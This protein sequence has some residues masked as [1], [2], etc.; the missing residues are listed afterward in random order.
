MSGYLAVLRRELQ[1]YFVSPLAWVILATFLGIQGALFIVIVTILNSPGS[2]TGPTPFEIQ[3]GSIFFWLELLFFAP[4]LTMRLIAEER[5]SGT[6][7]SLM[8]APITDAQVVL[9]KFT[10][11]LAFYCFLWLPTLLY[12][13]VVQR[14][15]A[16]DWGPLGSSYLGVLGIGCLVL[17]IGI[18]GSSCAKNQI[19]AAVITFGLLMMLFILPFTGS[20]LQSQWLIDALKYLNLPDHMDEL[21]KGIVDSR[22]LVYYA[23]MTAFFLFLTTRALEAKKWR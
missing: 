19:V 12:P 1:A 23:S 4:V 5:R 3:F 17:S 13:L 11:S 6:I 9:A 22:R 10:A 14:Y 18:F 20:V 7:E 2:A 16:V 8:T 15:T 21:T